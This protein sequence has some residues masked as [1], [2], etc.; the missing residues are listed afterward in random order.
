[1]GNEKIKETLN[2]IYIKLEEE[3]VSLNI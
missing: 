3:K 1:M 2:N